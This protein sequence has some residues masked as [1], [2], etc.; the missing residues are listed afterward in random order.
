MQIAIDL[1]RRGHRVLLVLTEE[2]GAR[3]LE[4]ALRV[5]SGWPEEQVRQTLMNLMV[6]ENLGDI[7]SPPNYILIER[8][9]GGE[10]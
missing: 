9:H 3:L 1:A 5:M 6:E 2:P 7:E 4:R 10:K 8:A